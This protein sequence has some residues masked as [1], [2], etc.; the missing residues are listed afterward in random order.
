MNL[1]DIKNLFHNQKDL[2]LY[3]HSQ[4]YLIAGEWLLAVVRH[5]S[6]ELFIIELNQ[7][8]IYHDWCS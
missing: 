7:V 2:I 5:R 4:P 6:F 8:A 3:V 1:K